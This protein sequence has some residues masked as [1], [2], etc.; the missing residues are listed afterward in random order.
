M[1]KALKDLEPR[2]PDDVAYNVMYDTTVFVEATI[3]SVIH[4]LIEAFVLV[5]IVVF[6]FLGNFRATLIPIIAVPVALIGTFAVM[7]ALGYS[8]NTISLLALVLAIG[9]VVD[10]AIVV[11]EAVEHIL[12]H[13]PE[14][15][16][17][18][19]TEKAMGQVTA[20][21]IAITLV[22]LSVFIP[23]AFIPGITGQLYS[24]FAVAVSVSMVISAIN[25]LSLSPALC[26]LILRHRGKPRGVMA[27]LQNGIDKSRDGYVRLV[28]PIARRGFIA[29]LLVGGFVAGDRRH[30]QPGAVGLPARRGPGRLH[31]R[32]PAARRRLDQPHAEVDR[33]G[34]AD[35]HRQ[36]VDA[37]HLHRLGLQH[38]RRPQP[39]QPRPGRG[40]AE[41]VRRAQGQDA[42]GVRMRWRR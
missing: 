6:I 31:G 16:P 14:L 30:R 22:L 18:Q 2:F 20:P 13:E 34:R 7:L 42:D 29:L 5:A 36:A 24:Q 38:P 37:E 25:A 19:A 40:R 28:T 10:D 12:E 39:A 27:W 4:T 15:T 26:S 3:E 32:G 21:I 11:V 17:A 8:A 35:D 33:G 41:A 23:T 9:I 1:R